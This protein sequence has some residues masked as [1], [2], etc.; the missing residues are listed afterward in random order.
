M[1]FHILVADERHAIYAEEIVETI[2]VAAQQRGT[3]IARRTPEYVIKKMTEG[4]AIIALTADSA[5]FAGFCYVETWEHGR[6]VANS[7]LIVKPEFRKHNLARKIKRAAFD[8]SRRKFPESKIFGI[9]TS[10]AV[11]KINSELGYRP[12]AFADLTQDEDFWNGCR[13]CPN[14]DILERTQRKMC[15]CTGMLFDPL[16]P[17][18]FISAEDVAA[19][20]ADT[21]QLHLS[22]DASQEPTV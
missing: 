14:V 15:L 22:L 16:A 9:T 18:A 8:L 6:Y 1:H 19:S 5:T 13:S 3:G 2:F 20:I 10:A 7:G 21:S 17:V 12:V 11:M 4:K